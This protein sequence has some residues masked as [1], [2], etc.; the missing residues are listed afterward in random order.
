LVALSL[1]NNQVVSVR[2]TLRASPLAKASFSFSETDIYWEQ[3]VIMPEF[4]L[5]SLVCVISAVCATVLLLSCRVAFALAMSACALSSVVH[6][7]GWMYLFAVPLSSLSIIPLLLA[8]GLCIDY[9][10]HV[11]HE[12]WETRGLPVERAFGALEARGA[13][14][15]NGGIS[16]GI[17]LQLGLTRYLY[18]LYI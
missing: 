13:A 17:A 12:F 6:L 14:V 8:I 9:C 10:M 4:T 15:A 2:G 16:T 3:D 1:W 11:A 18:C 5:Q 7:I